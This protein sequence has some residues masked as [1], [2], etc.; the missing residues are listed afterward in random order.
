MK[1]VTIN[2]KYA[3]VK[4]I[5]LLTNIP[6]TETVEDETVT[7]YKQRLSFTYDLC[8][9]DKNHIKDAHTEYYSVASETMLSYDQYTA[10]RNENEPLFIAADK[11]ELAGYGE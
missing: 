8:D 2:L 6:F 3:Y 9:E 1:T 4:D 11:L 5:V 10:W 7:V